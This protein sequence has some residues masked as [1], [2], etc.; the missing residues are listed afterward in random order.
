MRSFAAARAVVAFAPPRRARF[1]TPSTSSVPRTQATGVTPRGLS[2]STCP[3]GI[4]DQDHV[5]VDGGRARSRARHRR[6]ARPGWARWR[7]W[8][9][10]GGCALLVALELVPPANERLASPEHLHNWRTARQPRQDQAQPGGEGGV[11]ERPPLSIHRQDFGC[12]PRVCDRSRPG[13]EA[14]GRRCPQQHAVADQGSGEGERQV[15][16]S[17][18]HR[19]RRCDNVTHGD[20]DGGRIRARNGSA[21]QKCSPCW[22]ET[23]V[24]PVQKRRP[25]RPGE[26]VDVG[27]SAV[28]IRRAA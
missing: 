25:L 20:L 14:R 22:R 5:G 21:A 17:D 7:Y 16:V 23:W 28:T 1:H 8:A 13:V 15:G 18:P 26:R 19:D 24:H 2:F 27:A 11:Q 4:R 3:G 6:C 12:V 10:A 9:L